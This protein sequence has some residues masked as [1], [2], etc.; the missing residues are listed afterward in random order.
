M[1]NEIYASAD[2]EKRMN[3]NKRAEKF[4]NSWFVITIF[5]E[6]QTE[7]SGV[8]SNPNLESKGKKDNRDAAFSEVR[9]G[10]VTHKPEYL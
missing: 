4:K 3:V 5:N 1:K 2:H 8:D 7:R 10:G 6:R 9:G